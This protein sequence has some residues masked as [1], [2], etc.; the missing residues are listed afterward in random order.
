[1]S[2]RY[3]RSCRLSV[4]CLTGG[5][6]LRVFFI[7]YGF[8]G[9]LGVLRYDCELFILH[10]RVAKSA[11][12]HLLIDIVPVVGRFAFLCLQR[13]LCCFS[14]F[15]LLLKILLFLTNSVGLN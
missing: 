1:M 10:S 12:G 6:V 3:C 7:V 14:Y 11:I 8:I 2:V 5:L 13:Y 4:F 15:F 9:Y